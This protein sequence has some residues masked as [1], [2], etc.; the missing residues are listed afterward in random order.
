[1]NSSTMLNSN[2]GNDAGFWRTRVS[3]P[4]KPKSAAPDRDPAFLA[5]TPMMGKVRSIRLQRRFALHIGK[6]C[7]LLKDFDKHFSRELA[8]LCVLV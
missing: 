3:A 8:G 7:R 5:V 6:F 1:M 4:H 2:I